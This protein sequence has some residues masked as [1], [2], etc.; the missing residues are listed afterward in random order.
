MNIIQSDGQ[1]R[2]PIP[3]K[4]AYRYYNSDQQKSTAEMQQMLFRKTEGLCI[5]WTSEN[6]G[7]I[8]NNLRPVYYFEFPELNGHQLII[9][10]LD[11]NGFT[12]C[13][14]GYYSLDENAGQIFHD[15]VCNLPGYVKAKRK[16][17]ITK[18]GFSV[19]QRI[20]DAFAKDAA[21]YVE[22]RAKRKQ[23][24]P[25]VCNNFVKDKLNHIPKNVEKGEAGKAD[26]YPFPESLFA[27]PKC[28][29]CEIHFTA[30]GKEG[31]TAVIESR[32]TA[33]AT[34]FQNAH[35][36]A[37]KLYKDDYKNGKPQYYII[38]C[39]EKLENFPEAECAN[40]VHEA[41]CY[42]VRAY[43]RFLKRNTAIAQDMQSTKI[44]GTVQTASGR[45]A[46]TTN[47]TKDELQ[48]LTSEATI[49]IYETL[50]NAP[51]IFPVFVGRKHDRRI[52]TLSQLIQ[53]NAR[54]AIGRY[55]T[56]Y[57][58]RSQTEREISNDY[59][60]A[61]DHSP[62][63][64]ID[65]DG[66]PVTLMDPGSKFTAADQTIYKAVLAA[67]RIAYT[68]LKTEQS[69]AYELYYLEGMKVTE[70][71]KIQ[72][73]TLQTVYNRIHRA[74]CEIAK[75]IFQNPEIET[76]V[77]AVFKYDDIDASNI[78]EALRGKSR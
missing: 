53:Y 36:A 69:R 55:R 16:T 75:A 28:V 77:K 59:S 32:A 56:K 19:L 29:Y 34:A 24:N 41:A 22:I 9:T 12:K 66:K 70:I 10:E 62:W 52:D 49:A 46:S 13:T 45:D 63:T 25:P 27:S 18:F 30:T 1:K 68:K 6:N 5:Y 4:E 74:E 72:N 33:T 8:Y 65:T 50:K 67:E 11:E 42:Y 17:E 47:M 7:I 38:P 15:F 3:P 64:I 44:P 73:T 61:V 71:A 76:L 39:L 57:Y 78:I 23:E 43:E 54:L 60:A 26:Q 2:I 20:S 31:L 35:N 51:T 58:R 14:T 21:E 37:R 40:I 48:E